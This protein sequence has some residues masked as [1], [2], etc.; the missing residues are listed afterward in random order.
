[1]VLGAI[2]AVYLRTLLGDLGITISDAVDLYVDNKGAID[3]SHDYVA[4][5]KTKHIERRHFKVRELV[6]DAAIRV[7]YIAT[8]DNVADIFTKALERVPFQQLRAK[9]LNM[10]RE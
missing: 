3:L 9:L 2:E 5:D 10:Q 6:Q 4:N 8:A 7:R 1:M